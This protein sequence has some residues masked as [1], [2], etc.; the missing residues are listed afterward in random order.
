MTKNRWLLALGAAGAF[1]LVSACGVPTECGK[2]NKNNCASDSKCE[3]K[4]NKCVAKT[5]GNQTTDAD[6][7]PLSDDTTPPSSQQSATGKKYA[8]VPMNMDWVKEC[9]DGGT[10]ETKCKD[11]KFGGAEVKACTWNKGTWVGL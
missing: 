8:C 9:K 2:R 11:L 7:Q 4:N 5:T 6:G 1:A 3:W 10:D